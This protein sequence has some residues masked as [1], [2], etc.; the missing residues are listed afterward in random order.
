MLHWA[1]THKKKLLY[2]KNKAAFP[3]VFRA[4]KAASAAS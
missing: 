2:L 4:Y 3:F 1:K